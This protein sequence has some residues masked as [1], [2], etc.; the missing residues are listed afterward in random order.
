LKK[1]QQKEKDVNLCRVKTC[2]LMAITPR[3]FCM[4][5][6]KLGIQEKPV[7]VDKFNVQGFKSEVE[8]F[9]YVWKTRTTCFV[10]GNSLKKYYGKDIW[11]SCFCHV[12]RKANGFYPE[13]KFYIN[14]VVPTLPAV[15]ELYDKGSL[16][17]ILAYEEKHNHSF[18][19]L[20]ELEEK[21]FYEYKR[22]FPDKRRRLR[23]IIEEYRKAKNS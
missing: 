3:G 5:H 12:L 23:P 13:F 10:T 9:E 8:L 2:R 19:T 11:Y 21:L 18:Q 22:E 14:N 16:D 17:K 4:F 1:K 20:F 15:H 7:V 6:D